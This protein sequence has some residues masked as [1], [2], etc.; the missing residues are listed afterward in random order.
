MIY[1]DNAA[2]SFKKPNTVIKAM[3]D[4]I[5]KGCANPGRG[6]HGLSVEAGKIL[7]NTRNSIA[8]LFNIDNPDRVVFC[9]N[10][11]EALNFGIKG[12]MSRGG[13]IITTSMEHNSVIRPI[14]ALEKEGVTHSVLKGDK[15][16][17]L[18]ID[19]LEKLIRRDTKLIVMTHSSNV[20]GNIYDI[21]KASSIA[22]KNG[23]LFM[24]DAAQS[25]GCVKLDAQQVDL[26]AFPGHKGLLGP[27][28]SGGLYVA[29]GVKLASIIEGGTGSL[30]ESMRQPDFFPDMLE[31]G[32]QNVPA[33][34][35]L[36]AAAEFLLNEGTDTIY[37]YEDSLRK[38]FEEKIKNI[39]NIAVYGADAKTAI[40][41]F[42]I[43]GKDCV[44][45]AQKLSDDYGIATRA[46]LHCAYLAHKTLETHETGCVRA[47]FGYFNTPKEVDYAVDCIY[48][49]SK[50]LQ[51]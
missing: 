2:T 30:S 46:G 40:T 34:A 16:G 1:L 47:S 37:E 5:Y 49:I 19:R 50:D 31:S 48:K 42:N 28:G 18:D 32:T 4:C 44:E 10:T 51:F 25:A 26:L 21:E 27:M 9:K 7:Y 33:V 35:G 39:D 11:T 3:C 41:A 14:K 43:A 45:V 8:Q 20:C 13:H 6:G 29:D 23:V 17:N 12:V 36:G 22:Q 38:R 15:N 24:V